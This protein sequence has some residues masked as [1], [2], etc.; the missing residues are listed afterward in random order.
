MTLE[1]LAKDIAASAEAEAK[2]LIKKAKA[3]AKQLVAEAEAKAN[4][5]REQAEQRASKE[6]GQLERELGASARQSNQKDILVARKKVLDTT[7]DSAR[8]HVADPGMN[9]RDAVLKTLLAN[10]KKLAKGSF[11]IRPVELDRAAI[12]KAAGDQKVGEGVDG[13]GGFILEAEDGSVSFDMRFDVLLDQAWSH[14]LTAV[15]QTL[16][17]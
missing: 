3:E 12:T 9:G 13:L 11:V 15:N 7:F 2:A 8:D 6:A 4:E 16:F 17:E 10:S 1:T 14:Q 5:I